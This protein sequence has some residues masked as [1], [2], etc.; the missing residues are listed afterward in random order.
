MSTNVDTRQATRARG[1]SRSAVRIHA[2][3]KFIA[4]VMAVVIGI[5]IACY[6]WVIGA[7]YT[8]DGVIVVS[9]WILRFFDAPVQIGLPL[10]YHMYFYLLFIPLAYSIVEFRVVVREKV[11]GVTYWAPPA[12][13]FVWL[14]VITMDL[15]TTFSGTG[16]ARSDAGPV[17]LWF[18]G[19][20]A[21]RGIATAVLT[22][23]PEW[24]IRSMLRII[25]H[26]WFAVRAAW[27]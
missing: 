4:T 8:V 27:R 10:P 19:N 9:N 6:I 25:V 24:L 16:V 7:R 23:L 1:S 22:F 11:E 2:V 15:T 21:A 17:A 26:S 18:A 3:E 5:A 14:V 20:A 13:L 12:M